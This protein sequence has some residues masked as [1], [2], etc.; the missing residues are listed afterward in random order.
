MT[1]LDLTI[2]FQTLEGVVLDLIG[3]RKSEQ[4]RIGSLVVRL[5]RQSE[6]VSSTSLKGKQRVLTELKKDAHL[7]LGRPH[8]LLH[9]E[10]D[11]ASSNM[12]TSSKKSTS[13]IL[14]TLN[15]LR[16]VIGAASKVRRIFLFSSILGS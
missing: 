12:S 3:K 15:V 2:R 13:Q 8:P 10:T 1:C 16:K 14:S 5:T 6:N 9:P 4:I 11:S 7:K